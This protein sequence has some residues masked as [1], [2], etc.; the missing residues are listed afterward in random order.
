LI[1]NF[2]WGGSGDLQRPNGA[3]A[4][5]WNYKTNFD[6]GAT[7]AAAYL[8]GAAAAVM[9][10]SVDE[11]LLG[12]AAVNLMSSN[13]DRSGPYD[14]PDGR[15]EQIEQAFKDYHDNVFAPDD[16][17]PVSTINA[18]V[19]NDALNLPGAF[20][21]LV[22]R[23]GSSVAKTIWQNTFGSKP[24]YGPAQDTSAIDELVQAANA[25]YK[26]QQTVDE[27]LAA[28]ARASENQQTIDE[29]VQAANAAYEL[30]K[31]QTV[32]ELEQAANK[33]RLL[34]GNHDGK[35]DAADAGFADLRI[36][37]D[38]NGDGR[39]QAGELQSLAQADIASLSLAERP[40]DRW[41]KEN[42]ISAV[43]SYT[44]AGGQ[45]RED[46]RRPLPQRRQ[47]VP[48]RRLRVR[49][50]Q[51]I[52]KD[53]DSIAKTIFLAH[54]I[55]SSPQ[56]F[57]FRAINDDGGGAGWWS[58]GSSIR[59]D[60]WALTLLTLVF[61]CLHVANWKNRRLDRRVV[62]VSGSRTR[63]EELC[64]AQPSVTR[65]TSPGCW[66]MSASRTRSPA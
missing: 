46:G 22:D 57:Y 34:D 50:G 31:Q 17:T 25:V 32:D 38:L 56:F 58:R 61:A 24:P 12:A 35:V 16:S 7:T 41:Q 53:E 19:T 62:S 52:L 6:G 29:L 63:K 39:S 27:L 44:K 21:A 30:K 45:T 37:R 9:G 28:A 60:K 2:I 64:D 51:C 59:S 3:L 20:V 18:I 48:R 54:R 23:L 14:L 8:Y 47:L 55:D 40:D 11:A 36:W 15:A 4:A 43:S 10:L 49:H 13:P 33:L 65:P 66:A 5:V 42:Y 1:E 26:K